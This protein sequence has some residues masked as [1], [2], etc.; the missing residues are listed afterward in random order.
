M[1]EEKATRGSKRMHLLSDL[2]K[3]KYVGLKRIAEDRNE[4]PKLIR[5]GS[6]TAACQQIT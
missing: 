4:W 2:M 1:N 3:G 6:H 5:A